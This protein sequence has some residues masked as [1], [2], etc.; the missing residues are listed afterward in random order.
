MI[1]KVER[2]SKLAP[3]ALGTRLSNESSRT[4]AAHARTYCVSISPSTEHIGFN[5]LTKK[6]FARDANLAKQVANARF[7]SGDL[8]SSRPRVYWCWFLKGAG[9]AFLSRRSILKSAVA[10]L[11]AGEARAD[12]VRDKI[13]LDREYQ[14]IENF[15]ASDAWSFQK[16]GTWS[17]ENRNR[18]ADLLFSQQNGIGLSCWRFNIGGGVNPQITNP[19]RTVETFE[20]SEGQYDWSRQAGERWFLGAAKARG[21]P[22]FLA[23]VNSPPGR[24]T[25][26][27]LTFCDKDENTTNLKRGFEAQYARYLVDIVEHFRTNAEEGERIEF[28]Y[29]SPVN[30]PQWDW[31]GHSQEGNRASNDDIKRI[32][33]ALAAELDRRKCPTQ[34]AA[35]E[36]GS[37]PD[38]W[39]LNAK[40]TAKWKANYGDYIDSFAD[41]IEMRPLLSGRISYH[42][43]G[44]DRVKGELMENR[45]KLGEKIRAH[46]GWQLWMS[47]YCI[48]T[49]SEG[50]GGNGRDLGMDTALDVARIIHLDLTIPGVSAWQWWTAVSGVDYKDGLIYTDWEKAGDAETIYPARLLWVLGNYSRFVRPGMRRVDMAVAGQDFRGFMG[51]AYKD[52][53]ARKVVAVYVNMS[54]V[55]QTRQIEFD[56][57]G[58]P[59]QVQS[60]SCYV[61][62]DT[63][64]D[65][66]R[67]AAATLDRIPVPARSVVTAIVQ[68]A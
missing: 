37:L 4:T 24:M 42:D 66:L 21:V 14:V 38:M 32:L 48:L 9:L 18:I 22:Q 40:A 49:G 30:E 27:G 44:S 53:G 56:L 29:V 54:T 65:E 62:S 36:S 59:R 60:V 47:E 5:E 61:T 20:I 67:K 41:D 26:N 58:R 31:S 1:S 15:G 46:P 13:D 28:A 45:T 11:A 39:R 6:R 19:W 7:W 50:R 33:Q 55:A 34:I 3:V 8:G 10:G 2:T 57:G 35:L 51:S 17:I 25:R 16:L 12:V 52:E 43:Y 63:A 68:F 64:G 23:F